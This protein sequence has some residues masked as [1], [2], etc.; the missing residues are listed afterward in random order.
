MCIATQSQQS[1]LES[2][3]CLQATGFSELDSHVLMDAF[4]ERA[5]Q[6]LLLGRYT[7]AGPYVLEAMVQY[8]AVEYY[9]R[10]DSE[11]GIWILLGIIVHLAMRMGYHRDPRHFT[12][13]SPFAGEIRRRLWA[14]VIGLD[15]SFSAQMGLPRMIKESQAD[16]SEPRNLLDADFDEHTTKLPPSRPETEVT[17][18]LYIL[19]KNRFVPVLGAISDLIADTRSSSYAEVMRLDEWLQDTHSKLPLA[20]KWRSMAGSITDSSHLILQRVYLEL[21]FYNG[22]IVLHRKYLVP[23]QTPDRYTYSRQVCLGAAQK[24][25]EYQHILDEETHPVGQLYPVRWEISS[26]IRHDFLLATSILCFYLRQSDVIS[27]EGADAA[28]LET[29]KQLLQKSYEIWQRS[30]ASSKE[31]LKAAEALSIVLQSLDIADGSSGS[32]TNITSSFENSNGNYSGLN[33]YEGE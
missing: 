18:M 22:Q 30:S 33:T 20:L 10:N 17:T 16:T 25:L 5:V 29:I 21:M 14:T 28:R 32:S 9:A 8:F 12:G 26:L 4:R 7:Q 31:A 24:L 6:C 3:S 11:I 15:L 1:P 19:A 27:R 2:G 23:S 13:I